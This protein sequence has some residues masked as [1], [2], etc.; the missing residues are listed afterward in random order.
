MTVSQSPPTRAQ[1]VLL[2][3]VLLLLAFFLS[4]CESSRISDSA[5]AAAPREVRCLGR[6]VPGEKVIH[7]AAPNQ[8]LVKELKVKRSDWVKKGDIVAILHNH[9]QAVAEL[10]NAQAEEAVAEGVLEQVKAGAKEA[11]LGAQQAVVVRCQAEL[12]TAEFEYRRRKELFASKALPRAELEDGQLR[13][14][15]ARQNLLEAERRHASLSQVPR[16]DIAVAERKL[17]AAKAKS[18]RAGAELELTLIRAPLDAQVLEIN[19]YPGEA[20]GERGLM[21]L[22]DTRNMTVEAEVYV[23]D[24]SRLKPGA[25]AR[26]S[27]DGLP[28]QLSGTVLEISRQVNA[29]TVYNGDPYSYADQRVVPVRI[30]VDEIPDAARALVNNRVDVAIQAE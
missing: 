20:P 23:T 28:E 9:E 14:D 5:A 29:N 26:I 4:A 22:G 25:R 8:A 3:V 16:V 11:D 30:A 12:K 18:E 6:L 17:A 7:L 15:K 27:G 19:T 2:R 21:D 1:K 10:H 24:V 13:L